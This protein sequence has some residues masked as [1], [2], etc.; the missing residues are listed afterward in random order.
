MNYIA[1]QLSVPRQSLNHSA[2]GVD[3]MLGS[4]DDYLSS[5]NHVGLEG[6]VGLWLV[7]G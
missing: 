5:F 2:G 3:Q 6:R 7:K 1:A 4:A